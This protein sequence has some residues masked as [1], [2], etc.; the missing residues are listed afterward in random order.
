VESLLAVIAD[1]PIPTTPLGQMRYLEERGLALL[2]LSSRL[3][4]VR[5]QSERLTLVDQSHLQRAIALDVDLSRLSARHLRALEARN[6]VT[7]HGQAWIPIATQFRG[8]LSPVVIRDANS[9][10]RPRLTL[11]EMTSAASAALVKLFRMLLEA[12]PAQSGTDLL[13]RLKH[14]NSRSRWLIEA[15]I[16]RLIAAGR[17]TT[18]DSQLIELPP[19][20]AS[21]AGDVSL[22][23]ESESIRTFAVKALAE[24]ERR[25]PSSFLAFVELLCAAVEE[26]SLAVLLKT[27]DA[28]IYLEY[29]APLIPAR[30]ASSRSIAWADSL[31]SRL[32]PMQVYNLSYLTMVSRGTASHH[33]T[34]EVPQQIHIRR[35]SMSSDADLP[36]VGRL[37]QDMHGVADRFQNLYEAGEKI[38]ENEL[39]SIAARIADLGNRRTR[40]AENYAH[41][42]T[43]KGVPRRLL[44]RRPVE[45]ADDPLDVFVAGSGSPL[46]AL[47]EFSR[48]FHDAQYTRLADTLNPDRLRAIAD[49]IQKLRLSSDLTVDNDPREHGAH[50]H[51]SRHRPVREAYATEPIKAWIHISLVDD[52]PSLSSSVFRMLVSLVV[53]VYTLFAVLTHDWLWMAPDRTS[54]HAIAQADAVVAVLLLVPGLLLTRLDLPDRRSVLGSIRLL[55]RLMAYC[56]VGA[57]ALMAAVV[58]TGT[59]VHDRAFSALFAILFLLAI[60]CACNRI[61][62]LHQRRE[63]APRGEVVPPWVREEFGGQVE[64]RL[65]PSAVTFQVTRRHDNAQ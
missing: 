56:A 28:N 62:T 6:G 7:G 20:A 24:L 38:L 65:A 32:S 34:L 13:H 46:A 1:S 14:E 3:D 27:T 29:D 39:Q 49:R 61:V 53:L 25:Q 64:S 52:P 33:V 21:A 2:E 51:W 9:E 17:S 5:R 19:R 40:D 55:P 26:Y 54:S 41:Y 11:Q 12:A 10:V 59:S 57:L 50:G 18:T 23:S 45:P 58:A 42:L 43:E 48:R 60:L 35:F 15:S 37:L 4:H 63:T 44:P 16:S 36:M 30:S 22:L 8:D 47:A 31:R